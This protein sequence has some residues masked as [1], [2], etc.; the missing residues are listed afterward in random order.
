[1]VDW[2][3]RGRRLGVDLH[4]FDGSDLAAK[5][6][7]L[8]VPAATLRSDPKPAVTSGLTNHPLIV[9]H[10]GHPAHSRHTCVCN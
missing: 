7:I 9:V 2:G 3:L 10:V 6:A 8:A 1:M 4:G 5:A